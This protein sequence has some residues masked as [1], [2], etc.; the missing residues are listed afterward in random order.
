M[1]WKSYCKTYADAVADLVLECSDGELLCAHT[2][3]V[4]DRFRV[5]RTAVELASSG[6]PGGDG[7]LDGADERSAKRGRHDER[8]AIVPLQ[9]SGPVMTVLLDVAYKLYTYTPVH[10]KTFIVDGIPVDW[11][12]HK[13]HL[14]A[15]EFTVAFFT[16]RP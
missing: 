6:G 15:R 9:V 7:G 1:D 12:D 11:P 16:V 13:D 10:P 4:A 8:V 3:V 2:K 14:L 5:I